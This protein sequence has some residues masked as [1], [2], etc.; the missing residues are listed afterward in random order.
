[1][2]SLP[3]PSPAMTAIFCAGFMGVFYI[4]R[5]LIFVSLQ[6]GGRYLCGNRPMRFTALAW[7]VGRNNSSLCNFWEEFKKVMKS[8]VAGAR[9]LQIENAPAVTVGIAP[10]RRRL[11][12]FGSFGP[13]LTYTVV[14]NIMKIRA[15]LDTNI[16]VT[17]NVRDFTPAASHW[18][19]PLMA[20]GHFLRLLETPL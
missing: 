9:L 17:L 8:F 3:M 19:I 11:F 4:N 1:M 5:G 16:L 10:S 7:A 6:A 20:P 2:T 18:H 13:R 12:I 15:V 14:G